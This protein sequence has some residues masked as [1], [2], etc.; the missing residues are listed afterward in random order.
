MHWSNC[1]F[2]AQC[3]ILFIL[4]SLIVWLSF[5]SHC[6]NVHDVI[7]CLFEFVETEPKA[8]TAIYWLSWDGLQHYSTNLNSVFCISTDDD[9]NYYNNRPHVANRYARECCTSL[10]TSFSYLLFFLYHFP[11]HTKRIW[12]E[13]RRI[14]AMASIQNTKYT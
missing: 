4:L 9:N 10:A 7:V 1:W 11:S 6:K 5:F 12:N 14:G 3:F 8:Y 2:L 13:S